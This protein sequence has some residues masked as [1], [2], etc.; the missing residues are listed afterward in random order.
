MP[1]PADPSPAELGRLCLDHLAADPAQ[2]AAFMAAAGY[3]PT[4]L[5][6][7]V[8]GPDLTRGLIDYFA[9]NEPL[10]LA[11]CANNRLEPEQFMRIW[12]G[13]YKHV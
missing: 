8:G 12:A 1:K 7:A 9:E 13:L 2:L 5:R 3:T 4:M 11:L 10:L 6:Q